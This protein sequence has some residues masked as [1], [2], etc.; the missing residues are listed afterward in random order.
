LKDITVIGAG[1]VGLVTSACLV[2]LGNKVSCID[3]DKE[4]IRQLHQAI[5]PFYEPRLKELVEKGLENDMLSF[6]ESYEGISE[7]S[8]IFIICVGT[9]PQSDGSTNIS[10]VC[11]SA[12][13]I[14]KNIKRDSIVFIKSTVPVGTNELISSIIK[15]NLSTELDIEVASHPEFLKEGDAVR[16]FMEP[17]RIIIGTF[18]EL[19]KKT[20]HEVYKSLNLQ[21]DKIIFI[22]P[23]AAELTKYAANS[24]LATKISFMNELSLLAD[25]LSIDINEIRRGIG[26]DK[27]IGEYF[28]YAGLGY[29]GSCFPKDIDS[30]IDTY[31]KNNIESAILSS[32]KQVNENQLTSFLSKI[33]DY[34]TI[35]DLKSKV[36]LIW[37]LSFKPNT[38]DIRESVSLKLIQK[39]STQVKELK[40]YDPVAIPNS[41]EFLKDIN[42]ITFLDN[43]YQYIERCDSLIIC[44]EWE[45]FLDPDYTHISKLKDKVIFDGRNILNK[46]KA[47]EFGLKYMGIGC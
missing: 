21:K 11:E 1:Y 47:K 26:S 25:N 34:Y 10:Y 5:I 13:G 22:S 18:S 43:Q 12:K 3:T 7:N 33:L 46:N 4:K 36:L 45:N 40:L 17:D 31:K 35:K 16:D 37:G 8:E 41:R 38:D 29:G 6:S 42:N 39:L 14:A 27:R 9:P 19:V 23:K 20:A 30:L 24:F 44:T 28:L 15:E 32:V 2:E